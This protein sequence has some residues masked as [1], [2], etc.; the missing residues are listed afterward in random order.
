MLFFVLRL[1]GIFPPALDACSLHMAI[2]TVD[3]I[4]LSTGVIFTRAFRGQQDI[5][6]RISSTPSRLLGKIVIDREAEI[7]LLIR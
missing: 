3:A 7:K 6:L 5:T 4:R 1:S 2:A